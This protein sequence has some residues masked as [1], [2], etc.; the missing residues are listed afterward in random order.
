MVVSQHKEL[1]RW[2]RDVIVRIGDETV[3]PQEVELALNLKEELNA[4]E[5]NLVQ[6]ARKL[7]VES[8]N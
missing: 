1:T 6:L 5:E 7:E 4:M 8:G 2:V 3:C